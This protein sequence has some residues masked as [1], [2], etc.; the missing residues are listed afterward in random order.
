M[1]CA[2]LWRHGLRTP[3]GISRELPDLFLEYVDLP[4]FKHG[5]HLFF[6]HQIPAVSVRAEISDEH[7]AEVIRLWLL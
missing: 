5:R 4:E 7:C 6:S 3:T 2:A 1:L